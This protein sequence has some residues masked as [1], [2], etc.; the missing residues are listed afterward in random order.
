MGKETLVNCE[1]LDK[2]LA[3]A[4]NTLESSNIQREDIKIFMCPLMR[5]VFEAY[6]CS[7][8]IYRGNYNPSSELKRLRGVSIVEGYET[9]MIIVT[10]KD[11]VFKGIKPIKIKIEKQ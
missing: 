2:L 1:G 8:S 7:S 11:A 4:T 3:D 5:K 10:C 6:L 9:D